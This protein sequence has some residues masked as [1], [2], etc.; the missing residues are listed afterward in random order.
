MVSGGT[1]P[2]TYWIDDNASQAS[3]NSTF[4]KIPYGQHVAYVV[5]EAGCTAQAPFVVKAPDIKIP[6]I[7]TP[8]NDGVNDFFTTDIIREAY[9]NA[10]IRIF[11]R[12][13]KLLATYK[14][15]DQ[16]WDG[17]YQG[18]PMKSTDYW[19]E[20]EVDDM[21]KTFTGHFTLMRQ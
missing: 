21:N 16:G 2:Y 13:G 5:D 1:S 3:S 9:P 11:D 7:L 6:V 19:Y 14:G 4:T 10:V 18:F 12:Y 15:E 8:N 17:T 20:V